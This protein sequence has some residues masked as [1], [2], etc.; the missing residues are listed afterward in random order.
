MVPRARIDIAYARSEDVVS[1]EIEGELIL[2]PI[3]AGVGD[4]EDNLFTLNETG[5]SLWQKLDGKRTLGEVVDELSREYEAP[6]GS[7]EKDAIGL[8]EALLERRMVVEASSL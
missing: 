2:V 1:R 3:V 4:M 5:R 7:I 8:V 6:A